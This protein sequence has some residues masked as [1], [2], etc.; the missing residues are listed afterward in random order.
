MEKNKHLKLF[1][2]CYVDVCEIMYPQNT[3]SDLWIQWWPPSLI[4]H[5]GYIYVV[6]FSRF[7]PRNRH[8]VVF[9]MIYNSMRIISQWKTTY[10]SV[11]FNEFKGYT[12]Q[13]SDNIK[14]NIAKCRPTLTNFNIK[15]LHVLINRFVYTFAVPCI[16]PSLAK[17]APA[18]AISQN[19]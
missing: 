14:V 15:F 1:P 9:L 6:V 8:S 2:I 4:L 11:R 10:F 7:C 17:L 13:G 18:S 16:V 5:A 19:I 3:H 12:G